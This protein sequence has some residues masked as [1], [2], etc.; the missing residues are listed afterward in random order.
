MGDNF[1]EK[2]VK[3]L[4]AVYIIAVLVNVIFSSNNFDLILVDTPS[5]QATVFNFELTNPLKGDPRSI[6]GLIGIIANFLVSL[7]I[8]VAVI[9]IIYAGFLMLT[10]GGVPARYQKGLTALSWAILGLAVILI[11]RGFVSLIQS[12]LNV[13]R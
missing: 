10:S 12:L 9:I 3:N 8:P 13:Q 11:G 4:I 1:I 7:A 6:P 2:V 5:I